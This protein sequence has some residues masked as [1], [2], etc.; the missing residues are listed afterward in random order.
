MPGGFFFL[1]KLCLT[2]DIFLSSL[3]SPGI[4]LFNEVNQGRERDGITKRN[5]A[6]TRICQ[7]VTASSWPNAGAGTRCM[8]LLPD[9]PTL[10]YFISLDELERKREKDTSKAFIN[11]F[12]DADFL[13]IASNPE[14][15]L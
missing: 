11:W 2:L 6:V 13:F 14:T 15:L 8:S 1:S 3:D 7:W 10:V 12:R 4:Y 5:E 9:S